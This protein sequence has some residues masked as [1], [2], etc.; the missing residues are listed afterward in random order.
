MSLFL[1][2]DGGGSGTEACLGDERGRILA[3]PEGAPSNPLKVGIER[4]HQQLARAAHEASA[5]ISTPAAR[6]HTKPLLVGVC[7]GVAGVGHSR[8]A[9]SS[10]DRRCFLFPIPGGRTWVSYDFHTNRRRPGVN[11]AQPSRRGP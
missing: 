11:K 4:A 5:R 1:G 3:Q 6:D 2:I 10:G 8:A 7:A 9:S